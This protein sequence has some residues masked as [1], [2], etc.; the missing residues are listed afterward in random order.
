MFVL[1]NLPEEKLE[2]IKDLEQHLGRKVLALSEVDVEPSK[3]SDE[4]LEEIKDI[5]EETGLCLVAVD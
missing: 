5:E 4:Q 3:L 1:A 2:E